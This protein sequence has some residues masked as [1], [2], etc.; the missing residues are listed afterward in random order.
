MLCYDSSVITDRNFTT[1]VGKMT[2]LVR[3]YLTWLLTAI[4][5]GNTKNERIMIGFISTDY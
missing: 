4:V 1:A 3:G 2:Q 5:F